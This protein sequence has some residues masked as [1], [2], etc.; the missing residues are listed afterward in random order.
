MNNEQTIK[1]RTKM[2]G[3][4]LRNARIKAGKS[5]TETAEWLDLSSS[6]LSSYELGRKAA[7]LPELELL[8]CFFGTPVE[9]FLSPAGAA[10]TEQPDIKARMWVA[11]RQR[12]I[13]VFLRQARESQGKTLK[14]MGEATSFPASRISAYERGERPIPLPDLEVILSTLGHSITELLPEDGRVGRLLL[15]ERVSAAITE[16]PQDVLAFLAEPDSLTYLNLAMRLKSISTDK[17]RDLTEGLKELT[18]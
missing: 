15:E 5:L 1:L 17:L 6:T 18:P 14:A 9:T 2:L 4:M 12:L 16:L 3:A 11:L 8:S 13:G 7:S 10:S